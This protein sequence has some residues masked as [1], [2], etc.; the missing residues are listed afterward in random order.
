MRIVARGQSAFHIGFYGLMRT[1]IGLLRQIA[2]RNAGMHAARAAVRLDQPR[3]D[4]HERGFARAV[5]PDDAD[6]VAFGHGQARILQK[7]RA[8]E[9]ECYI[10]QC[11]ERNAH[12]PARL[13]VAH[14]DLGKF[15]ARCNRFRVLSRFLGRKSERW[16][17][18][19]H[20]PVRRRRNLRQAT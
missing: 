19:R 1:E 17:G 6:A 16:G 2:Q 3:R 7:R 4:L 10:L 5:A 13:P 14:A 12:A 15:C 20:P 9:G 8:A 18:R 11:K